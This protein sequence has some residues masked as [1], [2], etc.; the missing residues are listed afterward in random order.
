MQIDAICATC[1]SVS[2]SNLM[3][4][5]TRF[6]CLVTFIP[7]HDRLNVKW[8]VLSAEVRQLGK[9]GHNLQLVF[10]TYFLHRGGTSHITCHR[11]NLCYRMCLDFSVYRLHCSVVII[12]ECLPLMLLLF[13]TSCISSNFD[14]SQRE[15]FEVLSLTKW[16][17][18]VT[19]IIQT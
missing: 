17:S 13:C 4:D 8:K 2:I 10:A 1:W 11:W 5:L 3:L 15:R 14:S 9:A 12:K 16:C 18:R 19:F 6:C 7:L